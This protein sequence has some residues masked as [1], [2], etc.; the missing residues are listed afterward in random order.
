MKESRG[1]TWIDVM[2][3]MHRAPANASYRQSEADC[4]FFCCHFFTAK[5]RAQDD[6]GDNC[7]A[8]VA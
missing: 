3:R 8:I 7:D 6:D 5:M 1:E 2:P 4:V